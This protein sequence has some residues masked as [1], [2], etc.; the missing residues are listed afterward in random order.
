MC[1]TDPDIAAELPKKLDS[2]KWYI[3]HG[4]EYRYGETTLK[5]GIR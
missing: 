5:T 4:N 2:A 1:H 3:W